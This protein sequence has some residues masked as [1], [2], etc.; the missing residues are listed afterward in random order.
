MDRGTAG[1]LTH[2]LIRKYPSPQSQTLNL[3]NTYFWLLQSLVC[4]G[5]DFL[6]SS[7]SEIQAVQLLTSH[8]N[9]WPLQGREN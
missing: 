2:A 9:T 3:T 1:L 5:G 6:P 8:L 4:V 7:D